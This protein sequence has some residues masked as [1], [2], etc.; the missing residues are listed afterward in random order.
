MHT[1]DKGDCFG[2]AFCHEHLPCRNCLKSVEKTELLIISYNELVSYSK[3]RDRILK[4]L[5]SLTSRHLL[6]LSEKIDHT[7]AHSVRIKIS[8]YLRDMIEHTGSLS[9]N[10]K[11]SKTDLAHYLNISYPAMIRE[12]AKMQKED[13]IDVASDDITVLKKELLIT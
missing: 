8:V 7:Q 11:L 12:F 4:N 6:M 3:T 13:I 5:L 10:M 9:F 2:I 1:L